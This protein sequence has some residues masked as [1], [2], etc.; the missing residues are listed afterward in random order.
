MKTTFRLFFYFHITVQLKLS[1]FICS[2]NNSSKKYLKITEKAKCH[3]H[4]KINK[5]IYCIY[6]SN[7]MSGATASLPLDTGLI[8][9]RNR[10]FWYQLI[11]RHF[12]GPFDLTEKCITC[13][14]SL[15]IYC[16][17]GLLYRSFESVV[18]T[19]TAVYTGNVHVVNNMNGG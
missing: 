18:T 1:V 16:T 6:S 5:V 2:T 19:V 11:R 14:A 7:G 4:K 9:P 3:L 8:F 12:V 17:P 13:I 15:Y 10:F